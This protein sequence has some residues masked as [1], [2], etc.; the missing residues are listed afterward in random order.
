MPTVERTSH[1]T[2]RQVLREALGRPEHLVEQHEFAVRCEL[3]LQCSVNRPQHKS[4]QPRYA[5]PSDSGS[6]CRIIFQREVHDLATVGDRREQ[7]NAHALPFHLQSLGNTR[8]VPG[9]NTQ[10]LPHDIHNGCSSASRAA[11][12]TAQFLELPPL[13]HLPAAGIHDAQVQMQVRRNL[14]TLEHRGGD[15][16]ACTLG[17]ELRR[18]FDKR[19][20][21]SSSARSVAVAETR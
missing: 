13:C 2:V 3:L 6:R 12:Q 1:D 17:Q 7:G 18:Q 10:A 5:L 15:R 21:R 19:G 4:R 16:F 11:R 8:K 14:Q 20:S 9:T